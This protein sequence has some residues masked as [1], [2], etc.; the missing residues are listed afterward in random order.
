MTSKT[1]KKRLDLL[2]VDRGLAESRHRAQARILAGEILVNGKKI[3]KAGTPVAV[4]CHVEVI[5]GDRPYVSRGGIK[6]AA[7][8][9]A[10][11]IDVTGLTCHD[12]GAS[13]GGFTDCL[14]QRGAKR[15]T[16]IDVG[17]G[18][19]HW[20]LRSDP[21]VTVLERTNVRHLEASAL[22]YLSDLACIDVSFISLK[23]VVPAVL[24]LLIRRGHM[25]CLVKPQFEVGRG[26]VGKGGVVRDPVLHQQVIDDLSRMFQELNLGVDGVIPS[27]ILGPAGNK[28]FLMHLQ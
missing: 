6:L 2:L 11:S 28:E 10:F 5:G 21:R 16:A 27:P 14:L 25:I 9:D 18:Q 3:T 20:K 15:V 17:Y 22:P 12:V 4:N 19:L 7:A 13:T 23:I 26:L 8:L 1:T 24:Q